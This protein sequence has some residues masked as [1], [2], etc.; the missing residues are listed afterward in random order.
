MNPMLS[1]RKDFFLGEECST[2]SQAY[3]NEPSS[4]LLHTARRTNCR[5]LKGKG[6][7]LVVSIITSLNQTL[8]KICLEIDPLSSR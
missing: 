6:N 3:N 5:D 2:D 8:F 7:L 4:S 1:A